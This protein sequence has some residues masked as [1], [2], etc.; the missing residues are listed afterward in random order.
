MSQPDRLRDI[1]DVLELIRY[2]RLDHNFAASLDPSVRT[3][4]LELWNAVDWT[5]REFFGWE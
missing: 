3:K 4:Y 1:A 2:I 5:D